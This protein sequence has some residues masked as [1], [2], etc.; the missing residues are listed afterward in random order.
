[1]FGPLHMGLT[2]PEATKRTNDALDILSI[3]HLTDR[4]PYTLS[5]G[6][7]KKVALASV[8]SI[9]PE[10]WLLD[11]PTASLDPRSQSRLIDFLEDR[12][13]EGCTIITT[14]HDVVL[15]EEMAQRVIIMSENHKIV[16]DDTPEKILQNLKLLAE[17]NLI[18]EHLHRH[19]MK[20]HRHQHVHNNSQPHR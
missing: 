10:V 3:H 1:M 19:A 5:G 20:S 6:E 9:Q 4:S 12:H 8:L 16:A 17:N 18:H 13:T 14:T 15:L 11:E 7:K 2:L